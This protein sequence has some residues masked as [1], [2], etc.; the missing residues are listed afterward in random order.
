M[1]DRPRRSRHLLAVPA[2][3]AQ[4]GTS[5]AGTEDEIVAVETLGAGARYGGRWALSDCTL[6]IPQGSVVA[7]VGRNGAG[8]TTLLQML[9][10]LRRPD[11]GSVTVLGQPTWPAPAGLLARVGFVA[12]GKPLYGG[13]RV[14]DLLRLGGRMNP[15]WDQ[16][17]AVDR[18]RDR[19]IPLD[20]KVGKLSGGQR[21]QVAL[22][23]ALAKRPALLLLDEPLSDLD[24]VARRE[25][26]GTLMADLAERNVTVVLSSHSLS[27]LTR[28]CDW[29]VLVDSAQL[30][31]S[32]SIDVLLTGH[33][34]L[35]GPIE[36]ADR[37]AARLS[38]VSEFRGDRQAI[39]LVAGDDPGV[40][41]DPRWTIRQPTVEDLVFAYM[42]RAA[43]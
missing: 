16:P 38:V 27:D 33:Q 12:Q 36:L 18:L 23:M 28:A 29:L 30:R 25:V 10:G 42:K 1:T 14:A 2:E 39:L 32:A 37:A 15:S 22:V 4:G 7:V 26:M 40:R 21:T 19:D 31:L 8:K 20:A 5:S 34:L 17:Y 3:P 9:A 43:P 11:A 24:P 13:L 41:L 6:R 35:I